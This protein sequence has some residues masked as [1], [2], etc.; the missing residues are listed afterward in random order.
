MQTTKTGRV[1]ERRTTYVQGD[2]SYN[3]I[4]SDSMVRFE[5]LYKG[6][7]KKRFAWK[8]DFAVEVALTILKGMKR[9]NLIKTLI[10]LEDFHPGEFVAPASPIAAFDPDI[11][12][13]V[14]KMMKS[15]Q[16]TVGTPLDDIPFPTE[17]ISVPIENVTFNA[18]PCE[19]RASIPLSK[20]A[21]HMR[22]ASPHYQHVRN[23]ANQ[24]TCFPASHFSKALCGLELIDWEGEKPLPLDHLLRRIVETKEELEAK[25]KESTP[26]AAGQT[27]ED[28]VEVT[29][30]QK[31][32]L[33]MDRSSASQVQEVYAH[34]ENQLTSTNVVSFRSLLREA[35]EAKQ[36]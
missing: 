5:V 2:E 35:I 4:V 33:W 1:T 13:E 22:P 28:P 3:I 12:E 11:M 25:E 20:L 31:I 7:I 14:E 6:E 15:Q 24:I 30:A 34:L 17:K 21:T 8:L 16:Y 27:S 10:S 36:E 26:Q 23:F 19:T 9:E 32:K 29:A 18:P